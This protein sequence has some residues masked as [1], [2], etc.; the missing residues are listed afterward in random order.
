[1]IT[2]GSNIHTHLPTHS[3]IHPF[4]HSLTHSFTHSFTHSPT[5]SLTHSLIHSHTYSFTHSLTHTLRYGQ[6]F[7]DSNNLTD[8]AVRDCSL[9]TLRVG[10]VS[11]HTHTCTHTH[12][13]RTDYNSWHCQSVVHCCCP[14]KPLCPVFPLFRDLPTQQETLCKERR[15]SRIHP[16]RTYTRKC[17]RELL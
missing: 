15:F 10:C 17:L 16:E 9:S 8:S 3:P 11:L 6:F 7:P 2:I 5:H 14:G 13:P 4:T 1:M 12:T